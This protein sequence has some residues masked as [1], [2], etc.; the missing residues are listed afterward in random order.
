MLEGVFTCRLELWVEGED[1]R[2]SIVGRRRKCRVDAWEMLLKMFKSL[3]V[4]K[5]SGRRILLAVST[6]VDVYDSCGK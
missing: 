5:V 3:G 1:T 2:Q 6:I 4:G